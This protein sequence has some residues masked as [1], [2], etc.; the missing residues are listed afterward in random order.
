MGFMICDLH[1]SLIN[2]SSGDINSSDLPCFLGFIGRG[3]A[4]YPLM[5]VA[6]C[7]LVRR[8]VYLV[9]SD[10]TSR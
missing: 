1:V 3:G 5:H 7:N 8:C 10:L 2:P 9:T 6:L 4:K